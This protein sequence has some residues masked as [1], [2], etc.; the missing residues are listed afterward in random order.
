ML[1][2]FFGPKNI[3]P[4]FKEDPDMEKIVNEY[5]DLC[6][7]AYGYTHDGEDDTAQEF[8]NQAKE[9]EV[10][11]GQQMYNYLKPYI[12]AGS[13]D[14]SVQDVPISEHNRWQTA[15]TLQKVFENNEK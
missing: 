4:G 14:I 2:K 10:K 1:E 7:K 6:R 9:M 11:F 12:D 3:V 5:I 15:N 8:T 13:A